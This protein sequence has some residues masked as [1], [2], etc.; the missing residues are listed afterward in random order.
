[1]SEM[2]GIYGH[3]LRA[4]GWFVNV[5]LKMVS[6]SVALCVYFLQLFFVYLWLLHQ[7]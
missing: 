1:M 5:Y 6:F 4:K 2:G 3:C 7:F